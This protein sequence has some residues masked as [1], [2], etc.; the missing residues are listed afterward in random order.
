[1]AEARHSLTVE[2]VLLLFS[3]ADWKRL[4]KATTRKKFW[5]VV[6]KLDQADEYKLLSDWGKDKLLEIIKTL[7]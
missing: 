4:R 2:G 5:N 6:K 1:V 3:E 7:E